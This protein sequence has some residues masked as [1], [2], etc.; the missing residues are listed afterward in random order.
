[1]WE[2]W[3]WDSQRSKRVLN[4]GWGREQCKPYGWSGRYIQVRFC[5]CAPPGPP[6]LPEPQLQPLEQGYPLHSPSTH[7]RVEHPE[8]MNSLPHPY[9]LGPAML[10]AGDGE[11]LSC[12]GLD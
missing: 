5:V 2:L 7:S 4:A 6:S 3:A 9:V 12:T 11:Q 10:L 1:M 8:G